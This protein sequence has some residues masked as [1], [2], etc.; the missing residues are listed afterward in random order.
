MKKALS[1]LLTILMVFTA[2]AVAVPVAFAEEELPP[3]M[4]VMTDPTEAYLPL[5]AEITHVV[6]ADTDVNAAPADAWDVSLDTEKP[7]KAWIEAQDD[8]KVLYIGAKGGVTLN[9]YSASLF[10][11]FTSVKEISF[12]DK[13]NT[14]LVKSMEMMFKDCTSLESVDLGA[15]DTSSVTNFSEMFMGC[16]SFTE[17]DLSDLEINKATTIARML[18]DCTAVETVRIDTWYFGA[19]LTDMSEFFSGCAKLKKVYIYDVGYHARSKPT[20]NYVYKGVPAGLT[21]HDNNNIG[22]DAEIWDR[23]FNDANGAV[24]VFDYPENYTV[25]LDPAELL[26]VKGQTK[27]ITYKVLPR[28]ENSE[29]KWESSDKSV[30]TVDKEGNVTAVGLGTATVTVTNTTVDEGEKKVSTGSCKVSVVAPVESDYYKI[31]FQKPDTIEY[32]QVSKDGGET[33]IPVHGGTFEY[34]K[35]TKLII[36]AYGNAI[37]YIF[38]VNGKEVDSE[39]E[40]RLDLTVNKDKTV[41][42]RAI[43]ARS[44]EETVSFFERILQWF[45][46]LFDKLFGWMN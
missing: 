25:K 38:S 9:S 34:L 45:R 35:D 26:M 16:S 32:F 3:V 46:D 15:F 13:V 28:P 41:S 20:Q 37:S 44:G 33:Y 7:V 30:A 39:F 24:L 17:L 31:T 22:T 4:K 12:S 19:D 23:F 8:V 21:F 27:T 5:K 40:N 10:E 14:S 2:F 18:K 6:F 11:G 36:K 42:V 1:L 29:I 43:D